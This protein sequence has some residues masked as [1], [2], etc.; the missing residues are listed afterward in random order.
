MH[1]LGVPHAQTLAGPD[2]RPY[3]VYGGKPMTALFS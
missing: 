1:A 3:Q 2:G